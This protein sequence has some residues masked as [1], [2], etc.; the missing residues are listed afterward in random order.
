MI[1]RVIHILNSEGEKVL[2]FKINAKYA[3]PKEYFHQISK[4]DDIKTI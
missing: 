1:D 3:T 4:E 2:G